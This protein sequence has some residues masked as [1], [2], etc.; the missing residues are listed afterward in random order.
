MSDPQN[1][2][3]N[4]PSSK[5]IKLV[6]DAF[7][8]DDD[9]EEDEGEDMKVEEASE[10]DQ[11]LLLPQLSDGMAFHL[12]AQWKKRSTKWPNLSRIGLQYLALPATYAIVER[13][14]SNGGQ[15]KFVEDYQG[16]Y[17]AHDVIHKK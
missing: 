15:M 1:I 9:E 8:S 17:F 2:I 6:G 16:R 13:L 4:P 7:L 10:V 14:F 12:M 11:Y 3:E 5:K